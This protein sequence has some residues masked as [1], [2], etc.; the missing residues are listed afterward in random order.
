[1][2]I[3]FPDISAF[4]LPKQLSDNQLLDPQE[5]SYW[6]ARQN[7]TFYIDYD[8]DCETGGDKE[9]LLLT[10]T[11]IEINLEEKDIPE[12]ELKPI[13][14]YIN[15]L[16]GDLDVSFN[17]ADIMIASR[18]PIITVAMG[19]VMSAGFIIFLAGSRRYVFNHSNLLVHSGS[20][21]LSGTAEQVAAAQ[22]NYK[23]LLNQ[24]KYFI[25][26]RTEI[27][28]K[29]FNKNRAKDW[30][31]TMDDIVNYKIATLVQKFE[32]IK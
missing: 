31:L 29:V 20:A 11:I 14:I 23:M 15:T 7:R 6:K 24:M 9:L 27:P 1:M 10:K 8:I 13:T 16:G 32:D 22:E 28:E 2:D 4:V 17:L 3:E 21:S 26:E 19:S 5:L 12:N 18:I 25:L 30:Y